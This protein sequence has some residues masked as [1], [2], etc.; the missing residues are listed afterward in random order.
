MINTVTVN[1]TIPASSSTSLAISGVPAGFS[2]VAVLHHKYRFRLIVRD[3][4]GR[5]DID[6]AY[7]DI[8]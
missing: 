5:W 8:P 4:A 6:T 2:S 7:Y 3:S 1:P